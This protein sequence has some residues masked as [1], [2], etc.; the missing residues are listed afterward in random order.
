M[1]GTTTPS[2]HLMCV[3]GSS[4]QADSQG[5][6]QGGDPDPSA[7]GFKSLEFFFG[8]DWK[9]LPLFQS[10]VGVRDLPQAGR[11]MVTNS[12]RMSKQD[13]SGSRGRGEPQTPGHLV[14][15]KPGSQK[16]QLFSTALLFSQVPHFL[17]PNPPTSPNQ[18]GPRFCPFYDFCDRNSIA[19]EE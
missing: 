17:V 7:V 10:T 16:S 2:N 18:E 9:K 11:S 15:Q 13:G 3:W 4:F 6:Q 19:T 1:A 12:R 14:S 5:C 8:T